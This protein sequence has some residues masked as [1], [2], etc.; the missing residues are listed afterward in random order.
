MNDDLDVPLDR[1]EESSFESRPQSPDAAAAILFRTRLE[2]L[3]IRKPIVVPIQ[4]TAAEACALMREHRIG[5]VL[6]MDG[7]RLAGIFT[8]RDVLYKLTGGRDASTAPI[9]E[10]MTP[11]PTTLKAGHLLAHALNKMTLDGCRHIPVV[12]DHGHP[13]SVVS[14]RRIVDFLVE[15]F[16]KELA[17]LPPDPDQEM[18]TAEGG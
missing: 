18:G 11:N 6:V 4:A 17:N 2:D 7:A 3:G 8:E 14:V 15:H 10:L 13:R 5:C 9:R 16:A 12:D 1:D